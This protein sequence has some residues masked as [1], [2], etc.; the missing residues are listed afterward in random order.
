[1]NERTSYFPFFPQVQQC[2][3]ARASSQ[4]YIIKHRYSRYNITIVH[5][6]AGE[7]DRCLG[8]SLG[9]MANI[10]HTHTRYTSLL[11]DKWCNDR[12]TFKKGNSFF[13][14]IF[15]IFLFSCEFVIHSLYRLVISTSWPIGQQSSI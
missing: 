14:E 15:F 4:Q 3:L 6:I 10:T 7:R 9:C 8:I 2:I 11:V 13:W 1:V 12:I 5:S